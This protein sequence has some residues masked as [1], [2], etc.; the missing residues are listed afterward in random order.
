MNT[1]LW[2]IGSGLLMSLLSLVGGLTLYMSEATFKWVLVP[3]VAFAAGTLF[4]GATFHMLPTAMHHINSPLQIAIWFAIGFVSFFL[5]EQFL[6]WHHQHQSIPSCKK[7]MTYLILIGDGVHNLIGG[8][9][10]AGT[11]MIDLKLGIIAW[12]IAAAHEI[13]QELGDYAV[14]VQ[15]GWSKTSALFVN[16]L[17]AST[18]LLGCFVV[19]LFSSFINLSVL[20]PLAAGNF[21][22]IAASDL[23]PEVRQHPSAQSSLISTLCF[24]LGLLLLFMLAVLG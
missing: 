6:H 13:P 24:L 12:L 21:I 2:I 8:V 3:L 10:I 15:G 18:F 9:T 20:I 4:G 7:P 22:Y 23:I 14:L 11:F 16:L 19:I 5:I 1:S 17:S